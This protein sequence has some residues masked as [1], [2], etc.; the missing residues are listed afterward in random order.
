[1]SLG[2]N[3]QG[4]LEKHGLEQ[5]DLAKQVNVAPSTVSDWVNGK[6]YPRHKKLKAIATS[7]KTTVA[8]LVA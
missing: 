1:M 6:T 3:I 7:L 5:K 8:K 2:E 4:L